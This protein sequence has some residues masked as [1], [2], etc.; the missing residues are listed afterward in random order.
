MS[1]PESSTSAGDAGSF[2]RSETANSPYLP[3]STQSAG[4]YKPRR[5]GETHG[6]HTVR[7]TRYYS[8]SNGDLQHMNF[9]QGIATIFGSLGTGSLFWYL[10]I[11][12]SIPPSQYERLSVCIAI[13]CYVVAGYAY[14]RKGAQL[15]HIKMEHDY[16]E[17]RITLP[18][19]I[20]HWLNGFRD[21]QR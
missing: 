5:K 15:R 21:V 12:G 14:W 4:P 17:D 19:K 11:M 16:P 13:A 7:T 8:L 6:V 1:D 18:M 9:S 10:Q 20:R 3:A 2:F